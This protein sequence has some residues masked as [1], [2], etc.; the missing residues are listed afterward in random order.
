MQR[1]EPQVASGKHAPVAHADLPSGSVV[2]N[3]GRVS[4]AAEHLY[5][6]D[7]SPFTR[8]QRMRLDDALIA[9]NRTTQVRFNVYVGDLGASTAAGADAILK[10]TPNA[11]N[12][13]LIAVSPNQRTIEIRGGAAATSVTDT[14]CQLGVTAAKSSLAE[15]DLLDGVVSAINVIASAITGP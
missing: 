6:F 2:T 13:V 8:G 15:G 10:T 1:G 11:D 4:S 14:V 7:P 9:A 12:S 3:S 5:A